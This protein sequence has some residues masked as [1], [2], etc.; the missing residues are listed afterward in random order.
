[1]PEFLNYK[2]F[3]HAPP[4]YDSVHRSGVSASQQD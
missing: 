1:M 2:E 4:V 3:G